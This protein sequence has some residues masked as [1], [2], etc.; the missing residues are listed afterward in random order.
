MGSRVEVKAPAAFQI[1]P[2]YTVSLVSNIKFCGSLARYLLN[3]MHSASRQ[4]LIKHQRAS[5]AAALVVIRTHKV[6]RHLNIQ[7]HRPAEHLVAL[8][9]RTLSPLKTPPRGCCCCVE[10][11]RSTLKCAR[12]EQAASA[13][14]SI[15]KRPVN[16]SKESRRPSRCT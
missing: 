16:E 7:A 14:I 5:K 15:K 3:C 6:F 9:G 2:R 12:C 11:T 13:L 4:A 1:S 10:C 8:C